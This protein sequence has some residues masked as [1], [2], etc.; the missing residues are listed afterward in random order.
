MMKK[1]LMVIGGI[2]V[3][4]IVLGIVVFSCVS[5]TSKKM[6]CKSN[7]GNITLMYNKKTITGYTSKK[8]SYD[9]DGQKQLAEQMGVEAYLDEFAEWFK[10]NTTGTCER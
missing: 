3:G 4:F 6:K 9:L 10:N 1:V 7:E 2:V 8:I 5:L